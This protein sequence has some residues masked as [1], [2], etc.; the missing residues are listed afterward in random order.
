MKRF[1]VPTPPIWHTDRILFIF[2][3]EVTE[4]PTGLS[5]ADNNNPQNF[6]QIKIGIYGWRKRC[7]YGFILTLLIMVILN[8]ALSFWI[9][10]VMEFSPVGGF[11]EPAYI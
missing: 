10:K 9:L 7:I 4:A 1:A 5:T 3:M 2:R 8:L 6:S 11:T